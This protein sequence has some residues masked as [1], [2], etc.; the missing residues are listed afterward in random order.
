MS[1]RPAAQE[2]SPS[3]TSD[4][5]MTIEPLFEIDL[6]ADALPQELSGVLVFRK[7]ARVSFRETRRWVARIN[8]FLQE[9]L[10]GM[11]V[12]QLFR[13]ESAHL[14]YVFQLAFQVGVGA[15]GLQQLRDVLAL[16]QQIE[17]APGRLPVKAGVAALQQC[18]G[19]GQQCGEQAFSIRCHDAGCSASAMARR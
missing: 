1:K 19:G 14:Q 3:A 7:G 4:A 13:R 18:G 10:S 16:L 6:G 8:A 2:A 5:G 12:V 17:L 11:S 9:N 15:V